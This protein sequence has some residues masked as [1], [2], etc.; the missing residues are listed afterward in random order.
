MADPN[1][2][3]TSPNSPCR[4]PFLSKN[5]ISCRPSLPAPRPCF[6]NLWH[7]AIRFPEGLQLIACSNPGT[8]SEVACKAAVLEYTRMTRRDAFSPERE[9]TEKRVASPLQ[10][11]RGSSSSSGLFEATAGVVGACAACFPID[12]WNWVCFEPQPTFMGSSKS[13]C[14]FVKYL[15]TVFDTPSPKLC[16]S[17]GSSDRTSKVDVIRMSLRSPVTRA[18]SS[19]S[20]LQDAAKMPGSTVPSTSG[21]QMGHCISSCN[22]F[23]EILDVPLVLRRRGWRR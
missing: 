17:I 18:K 11:I 20:G 2:F 10:L 16:V 19:S 12:P 23:Q 22:S 5:T 3:S 8:V 14:Q 1:S 9:D 21:F 6:P 13:S 7:E 15:L 4:K